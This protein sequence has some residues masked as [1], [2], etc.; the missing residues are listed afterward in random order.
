MLMIM[1]FKSVYIA[2]LKISNDDNELEAGHCIF[3][4]FCNMFALA[5]CIPLEYI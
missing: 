4:S 2:C 5:K 3:F 1:C